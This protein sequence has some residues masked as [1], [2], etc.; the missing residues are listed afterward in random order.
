M[1]IYQSEL[2]KPCFRHDMAY[3]G[4]EYLPSRTTSDK[5]LRAKGF[6]ISKN[7]KFNGYQGSG[8][9]VYNIFDKKSSFQGVSHTHKSPII[10]EIMKKQSPL[11]LDCVAKVSDFTRNLS[12]KLIIK[13]LEKR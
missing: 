10:K 4:F 9:V 5:V 1:Y 6:N 12:G 13:N 8:S 2:D 3:G 7:T 11:D